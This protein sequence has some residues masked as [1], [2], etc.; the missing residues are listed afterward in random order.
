MSC[1][2]CFATA[3]AQK[4]LRGK[5]ECLGFMKLFASN[6]QAVASAYWLACEKGSINTETLAEKLALYASR[7]YQKEHK[8]KG[9]GL[10]R[11]RMRMASDIILRL[12][13]RGFLRI[14]SKHNQFAVG[15][16]YK[17]SPLVSEL[18]LVQ[19][20]SRPIEEISNLIPIRGVTTLHRFL[21]GFARSGKIQSQNFR[22]VFP[23]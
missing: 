14:D 11:K 17:A 5:R 12:A 7:K 21:L 18:L 22:V 19:S 13:K 16:I 6:S 9:E 4:I 1:S 3:G 8:L 15:S 10:E 23:H 20:L 2:E